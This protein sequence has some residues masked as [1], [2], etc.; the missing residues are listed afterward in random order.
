MHEIVQAKY[1]MGFSPA[2]LEYWALT[3]AGGGWY[4]Q[5]FA[6][7]TPGAC[8]EDSWDWANNAV[9]KLGVGNDD[10][11]ILS[12]EL[13]VVQKMNMGWAPLTNFANRQSLEQLLDTLL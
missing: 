11:A 4:V 5:S 6:G 12:R 10:V 2:D 13:T 1:A 9:M 8:F 3:D 7:G